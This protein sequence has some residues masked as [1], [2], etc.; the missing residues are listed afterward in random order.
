MAATSIAGV[1][2]RAELAG[3]S[4][5]VTASGPLAP[6]AFAAELSTYRSTSRTGIAAT[7]CAAA[8]PDWWFTG[9]DTGVGTTTHLELANPGA[10]VAVVDLELFGP[11]GGISAPGAHDVALAPRSRTSVDLAGL[12]PGLPALLLHV[13]AT[14][15]TVAAAVSVTRLDGRTPAGVDWVA[16]SSAPRPKLVVDA[17]LAGAT[18]QQLVVANPGTRQQ[19]VAI[20]VLDTTGAFVPSGLPDVQVPPGAVV[21]RDITAITGGDAAAI[22]VSAG[23]PIAAAIRSAVS[24]QR[25]DFTLATANAPLTSP[26]VVPT[27]AGSRLAL[28]VTATTSTPATVTVAAFDGSGAPLQVVQLRAGGGTTTPWLL[29]A[30]SAAAYVVVSSEGGAVQAVATYTGAAG[31]AQLPVLPGSYRVLQPAVTAGYP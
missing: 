31:A 19:L 27:M 16:A 12:A 29:P 10:G 26:A 20:R 1:P 18:R 5:L 21:V 7:P 22:E 30:R 28:A 3:G 2:L 25:R 13:A 17:G 4:A 11:D 14:R 24:A 23:K 15:G 8:R 9:V 6:G